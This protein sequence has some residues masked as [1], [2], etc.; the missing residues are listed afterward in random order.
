MRLLACGAHAD[1]VELSCGG[2]LA[3][4]AARGVEVLILDLT[5]GEIGSNGDPATRAAEAAA[6]AAVLGVSE[7]HNARLRHQ[8]MI[9]PHQFGFEDRESPALSAK[10]HIRKRGRSRHVHRGLQSDIDGEKPGG[11]RQQRN[12]LTR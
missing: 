2:T 11:A 8:D 7:R 9:R 1:D 10:E 6:A 4:A 5:E 12:R 3:L